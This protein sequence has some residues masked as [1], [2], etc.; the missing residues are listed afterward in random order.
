MP[1]VQSRRRFMT[2]VALA[3]AAGFGGIGA[4][5]LAGGGKSLAE[6]PPETTTIRLAKM[7][8]ICIAPQYAVQELLR[9]E[10]FDDIR[11]VE[12]L[13]ANQDDHMARG[14]V[15]FSLHFAAPAI[16]ALDTGKPITILAGVHAGCFELFACEGIRSIMDLKNRTVGV[17]GLG[18]SQH[19][20]LSSM[21]GYV[22]LDP[23][24]DIRWVSSPSISPRELFAQGKIDAF[25]G[26]PPDPQILRARK[27]GHV[28]VN[29][30]VDRPWSQYF[31]C[32]AM[33]NTEFVRKHPVATRRLL[34]AVL[35]A[36][37]RCVSEPKL[38]AQMMVDGGFTDN[39]DYALE[40][41]SEVP[42]GVWRDYDPEDTIRF[43]ALRLQE[44]RMIKS[45]PQKIIA[46]GT[47]WRF[48][49]E[50]KRELKV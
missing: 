16:I 47:D 42:Y 34:R 38:V 41:L 49:N 48:L 3:G 23:A 27:I 14:A 2:N 50:L 4:A 29:S 19:V 33:A 26:F 11:Y 5:G 21:A 37:D 7:H 8:G 35:K 44:L 46:E 13:I 36:T 20:F 18:S 32:M 40:T 1:I 22:G 45:T 6:P 24:K 15:D 39:Y 12:V 9:A 17:Q 25:L 43:Y 31:C 28:V 10:G 30:S